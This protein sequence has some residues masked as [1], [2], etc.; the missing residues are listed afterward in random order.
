MSSLC[1]VKVRESGS[2]K[3]GFNSSLYALRTSIP[4]TRDRKITARLYT[5]RKG[6][7]GTVVEIST[8][9]PNTFHKS[10][11]PSRFTFKVVNSAFNFR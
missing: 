5:I 2:H 1:F 11:V 8:I 3:M 6:E 9:N 7:I 10:S 4:I